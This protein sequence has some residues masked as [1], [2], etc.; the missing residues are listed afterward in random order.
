M[1]D[2]AI[3]EQPAAKRAKT[4]GAETNEAIHPNLSAM[5]PQEGDD[6]ASMFGKSVGGALLEERAA[7]HR[8]QT[9]LRQAAVKVRTSAD[10]LAAVYGPD[11]SKGNEDTVVE[12]SVRGTRITTL[13]ST[14]KIFPDSAF[15]ARFDDV[16]WPIAEKEVDEHGRRMINDCSPSVSSKVLDILRMK[17]ALDGLTRNRNR[18]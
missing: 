15:A 2:H 7:L 10:A 14:L 17:S 6:D 9:E 16:K 5:P 18:G 13:L 12:L 8:A 4:G 3:A 1:V 11:V